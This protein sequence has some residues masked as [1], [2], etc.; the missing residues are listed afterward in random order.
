MLFPMEGTPLL[1]LLI[2]AALLAASAQAAPTTGGACV[3]L[4]RVTLLPG[5]TVAVDHGPDFDV[6]RV[7]GPAG[8]K[9]HDWGVYSGGF[10]QVKG[11]GPVLLSRNGVVVR[12]AIENGEFRGYLAAK[13]YGQD[14]FFGS[15]F[16][17]TDADRTFFDRVD[18]GPKG[19]ALCRKP[20]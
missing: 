1:H 9:G 11:N 5:E 6:Y 12:R 20:G 15:V 17:G 18:F 4:A 8:S 7:S 14:H 3:G 13:G 2:S 16:K 10:A 19:Q